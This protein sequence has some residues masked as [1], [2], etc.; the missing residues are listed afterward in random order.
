MWMRMCCLEIDVNRNGGSMGCLDKTIH[1][2]LI[3]AYSSSK[4]PSNTF[5]ATPLTTPTGH[6]PPRHNHPH[7]GGQDH[8][9]GAIFLPQGR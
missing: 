9:N 1:G 8:A 3:H 7:V 5:D 2:I 4:I 6:V